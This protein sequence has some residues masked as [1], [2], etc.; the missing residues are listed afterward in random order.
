MIR[1][2]IIDDQQLIRAGLHTLAEHDGDIEV[3]GGAGDGARGLEL[4]RE[5]VPD[6]VLMDLRMPVMDGMAATRAIVTDPALAGVRVLALT[7]FDDQRTILAAIRAGAA[8][9]ILKDISPVDLRRAIRTVHAGEALLSPTIARTLMDTL[10]ATTVD[11]ARAQLLSHLT[12]RERDVLRL[13]AL[14][15]SNS[16]IGRR[17]HISPD[18]ARTYVSRLLAKLNARDRTHL[19]ILGYETGLI[20]PGHGTR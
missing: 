11:P 17:L 14:G 6:V 19:V 20:T 5:H 7:T 15:D 3:L 8:G 1:I 12:A 16:E 4:V 18:T 2:V 13:I 10:T 9:Y